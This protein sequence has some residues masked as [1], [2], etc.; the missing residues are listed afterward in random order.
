MNK[1]HEYEMVLTIRI[2]CLVGKINKPLPTSK[3]GNE[4]GVIMM[5]H[6]PEREQFGRFLCLLG[7]RHNRWLNSIMIDVNTL[8]DII[9]YL[10]SYVIE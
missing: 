4:W 9:Y 2:I 8:E 10:H 7:S 6:E 1:I 5:A 3:E